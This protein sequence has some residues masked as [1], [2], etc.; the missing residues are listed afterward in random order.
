MQRELRNPEG[1]HLSGTVSL[2]IFWEEGFQ[3]HK[4]L[5]FVPEGFVY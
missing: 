2:G 5:R 3:K 4:A 1:G